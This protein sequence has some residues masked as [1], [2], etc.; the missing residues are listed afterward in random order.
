MAASTVRKSGVTIMTCRIVQSPYL[1]GPAA[2]ADAARATY[3]ARRRREA[4]A[5]ALAH[6]LRV[7]RW[8]QHDARPE[9]AGPLMKLRPAERA[10]LLRAADSVRIAKAH[11]D[12]SL[13]RLWTRKFDRP[14]KERM[15]LYAAA[16]ALDRLWR[17]AW[18]G[19][20]VAGRPAPRP[21]KPPHS[22][23]TRETIAAFHDLPA[24]ER[25][26]FFSGV[27]GAA[28]RAAQIIADR[29]GIAQPTVERVLRRERDCL[30]AAKRE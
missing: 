5:V 30:K 15:D 20:N 9:V 14:A 27:H 23:A 22:Q 7:A 28:R 3:E 29:T 10:V 24:D 17:S 13:G 25:A 16:V 8:R 1:H 18:R 11:A 6:E 21:A 26:D 4:A 19:W 2:R 12:L